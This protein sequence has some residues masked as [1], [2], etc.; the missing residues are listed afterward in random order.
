MTQNA[1]GPS[2]RPFAVLGVDPGRKGAMALVTLA[3]CPELYWRGIDELP[4]EPVAFAA[5][6]FEQ[7]SAWRNVARIIG[8]S[9]E[10]PFG[11]SG[12]G[13]QIAYGRAFGHLELALGQAFP[14]GDPGITLV[15]PSQWQR[16]I[17]PKKTGMAKELAAH[18][19]RS[20][21]PGLYSE[22]AKLHEGMVDA[23]LIALAHAVAQ[24]NIQRPALNFTS[25]GIDPLATNGKGATRARK[26]PRPRNA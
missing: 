26:Q 12:N 24:G 3:S 8:V 23:A 11:L 16:H 10:E 13:N 7:V 21:F 5:A 9:L 22:S 19:F 2:T 18:A 20:L 17:L 25:F 14:P 6:V 15:N 1:V 4:R